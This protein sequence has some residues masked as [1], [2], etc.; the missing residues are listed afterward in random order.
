MR[1]LDYTVGPQRCAF[2]SFCPKKVG[3]ECVG[4]YANTSFAI[5]RITKHV[6]N[7]SKLNRAKKGSHTL[8]SSLSL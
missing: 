5:F 1:T 2:V 3:A 8:T 7:S 6:G 4:R